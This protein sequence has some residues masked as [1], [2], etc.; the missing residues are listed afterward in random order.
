MGFITEA[1]LWMLVV[2]AVAHEAGGGGGT[3]EGGVSA[4]SPVER[5]LLHDELLE[6][7]D[8]RLDEHASLWETLVSVDASSFWR[9]QED[10]NIN[11]CA[12]YRGRRETEPKAG[13]ILPS[14]IQS[15][16]GV[17]SWVVG[18]FIL[19]VSIGGKGL[20]VSLNS[21]PQRQQN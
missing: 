7:F 4:P 13:R 10:G 17:M 8:T 20:S 3:V 18:F 14:L 19:E 21:E 5:G 16:F 11:A 1:S 2:N 9:M 15:V 6:L 12:V